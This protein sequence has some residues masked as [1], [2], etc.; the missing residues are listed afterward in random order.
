MSWRRAGLS[1]HSWQLRCYS[2][3]RGECDGGEEATFPAAQFVLYAWAAA[4]FMR[5][6][7]DVYHGFRRACRRRVAAGRTFE[8]CDG[9][10]VADE[11]FP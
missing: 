5:A 8:A 1:Q 4:G 10:L 2:E 11:E 6:S 3:G 7:D 9:R